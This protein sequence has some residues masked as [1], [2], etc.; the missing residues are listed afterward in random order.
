MAVLPKFLICAVAVFVWPVKPLAIS[1][2][3]NA[4]LKVGNTYGV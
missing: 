2:L 3:V 1:K 4:A